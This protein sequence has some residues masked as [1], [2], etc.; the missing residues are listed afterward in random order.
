MATPEQVTLVRSI[1]RTC[2]G[3]LQPEAAELKAA[4]L[5]AGELERARA[6]DAKRVSCGADF[7]EVILAGPLDGSEQPYQ[8]P[9]CGV[10]GTYRAPRFEADDP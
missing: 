7:N 2:R 4:A 10:S 9:Q 1:V 6:A 3:P 5:A 8:C